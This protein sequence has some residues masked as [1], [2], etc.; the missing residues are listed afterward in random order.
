MNNAKTFQDWGI[1]ILRVVVGLVFMVHGGQKLFMMG[2]DGTAGFFGSLG[3][4]LPQVAALVVI[5]VELV[6]GLA[7]LIGIGTRYV[8]ALLA[9]DM[10]VAMATVHLPN[11]FFVDGGGVEFVLT[12]L[13]VTLFFTLSG[14]GPLALDARLSNRSA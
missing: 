5:A 7:L 1:L 3:V 6:G 4:P 2:I 12:L 8:A 14:A 9:V 13:A 10:L 11:G